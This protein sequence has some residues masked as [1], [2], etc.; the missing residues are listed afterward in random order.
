MVKH[1]LRGTLVHA[2]SFGN[3]FRSSTLHLFHRPEEL[4]KFTAACRSYTG[5]FVQNRHLGRPSS[6][7]PVVGDRKAVNFIADALEQ[8]KRGRIARK[9]DGF[10]ASWNEYHFELLGQA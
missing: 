5:D 3:I 6:N 4:Q 8:K 9:L 7:V 1:R 10:V 2:G